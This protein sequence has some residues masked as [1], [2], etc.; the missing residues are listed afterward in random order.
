MSCQI[1]NSCCVLV[2]VCVGVILFPP[3][4]HAREHV[5]PAAIDWQTYL[6]AFDMRW[7]RL[8]KKWTQAP[9]LGNGEQGTLMYQLGPREIR[10]DVGCSAAHDHRPLSEDD[11]SEKHVE[12]LNRG[13]LVIGALRLRFPVDVVS[14]SARL[15]LWDAEATGAFDSSGARV[16][17]KSLVH[18][19]EPVIFLEWESSGDMTG[20]QCVFVPEQAKS[21]RAVRAKIER[22]PPHPEPQAIATQ[23]GIQASVQNLVAGGQTAV[24][25]KIDDSGPKHR[26]WLSVQHSYPAGD[27]IDKAVQAVKNAS[28]TDH[29]SWVASH[30]NWWH[31]YYPKSFVSTGDGYWDSFYWV[32][33]YKLACVTRENGWIIDNQ[34]PWLQPT[35]WNAVWWNLNAQLSHLGGFQANRRGAVS[36]L[37][38]RLGANQESL[39]LSV[40]AHYRKDSSALARSVSGWDLLGHAGEPGGRESMDR[41]MG[42]ETANLLWALHNV[43]L[44]YRYWMDTDLRDRVLLPLLIRAVNY[45]RHFLEEGDDGWLHLPETHSP[46]YR[47]A[48]DCTYDLDLLRW[49]AGRLIELSREREWDAKQQPLLVEWERIQ[50]KLVPTWVDDTGRMIGRRVPLKGGHRHWSH[51]LAV[52]PLR[53][54]TPE[55]TGDRQ[56]IEKSLKRWRSFNRGIAGY[57]HSGS[58]C[59]AAILRDGD[60]ALEYLS[61]LKPYLHPNTFYTEIGLP[62]METPLH[63]ATAVQEMLFQSWGG[64]LRCF[65]AVPSEWS[66]AQFLQFRGEGGFL[67]SASRSKGGTN[68]VEVVS[69]RGGEIEL[70][71]GIDPFRFHVQGNTE[72]EKLHD[73][74]LLLKTTHGS[75]IR[76]E[77]KRADQ[78]NS[79]KPRPIPTR[80]KIFRFGLQK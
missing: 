27:A 61:I 5:D 52:Y 64:R 41:N 12:V 25:W 37:S 24:A 78:E 43:D 59:M 60:L 76:V 19:T 35:A 38:H 44:E 36:A 32:Q 34:G 65:P 79:F 47:N 23:D 1:A 45:Y 33:Q 46:E 4:G 29:D 42:R 2:A 6:E 58:A 3:V 70:E 74:V 15:S 69:T 39:K 53:T 66:D 73:G 13:R 17:W 57:S 75:V 8:P 49:A 30:R 72:V 48:S 9:F 21:P 51:L 26:L 50:A 7:N 68:W 77:S 63:G 40:A 55:K 11:L 20:T 71:H 80:N 54:L 62:V 28:S 16:Q 14:G 56:L 22:Q 18:A 67:V 31:N 10:F